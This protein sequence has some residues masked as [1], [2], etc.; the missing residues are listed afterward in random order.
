MTL[1]LGLYLIAT[2]LL[3]L[4]AA[5]VP[6]PPKRW[7]LGWLGLAIWLFTYAILPELT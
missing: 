7:A 6:Q 1:S 4:A 2:I 3:L 5:G